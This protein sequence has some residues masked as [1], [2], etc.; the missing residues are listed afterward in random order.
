MKTLMPYLTKYKKST[1]LLCVLLFVQVMGT[2]YIPTLIADIVNNGIVKGDVNY[3]WK[4][5][6][7]MLG[8]AVATAAAS[9]LVTY[10]SAWISMSFA[11]DVRGALFR[12]VQGFTINEFNQFGSASLITRSTSDITQIQQGYSIIVELLLPA[13]FMTV[14]GLILAFSKDRTLALMLLG[15]MLVILL[16]MFYVARIILPIFEKMQA[17]MDK[18]NLTVRESIIGVR[19]IRSF[20]RAEFEKKRSDAT[21]TDYAA[22]AIKSNKIF[23]VLM[24]LIMLLMDVFTVL[25]IWIGG[26]QAAA[27]SMGIG[28]IMAIMEYAVLT[29]MYLLMGAA[30]FI[31][32]PRAQTSA[33]RIAAVLDAGDGLSE[34]KASGALIAD[35][36]DSDDEAVSQENNSSAQP[37]VVFKSVSFRYAGAEEA[38]LHDISFSAKA[39]ETTAIIGS[40][41]SGKSTIANLLMGLYE[42][43]S[44]CIMIDGRDVRSCGRDELR[45]KIGYVPQKAFLF[46]GTIADNLRHGKKEATIEEMRHAADIAQIDEF[47]EKGDMGFD[48]PVSQGGSNFSGGQKQRIAIARALIRQ[49]EIYLF[50]DSFSALDFKTDARLRAALAAEVTDSAVIIVAQRISTIISADQIIVLDDGR[51]VGRG[52]HRELMDGCNVYQQIAESQLS[53]EE[54]E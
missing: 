31:F 13:P 10:F 50:D 16:I 8:A 45:S 22:L 30:A 28:D 48:Q 18:I 27:G 43:D 4:V 53:E 21:F 9:V 42:I 49:P 17:M 52:T 44:G 23:A 12:K 37:K 33:K 32:I 15:F 2:L 38:V 3:V 25:I 11:T 51:I 1:A 6:E 19:V 35:A 20:N 40:T 47:I 24:P 39:G 41:G 7:I 46:S 5:G 14:A 36:A 29:L 26:N 54:L 34:N